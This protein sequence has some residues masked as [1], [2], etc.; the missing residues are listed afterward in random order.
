MVVG[1]IGVDSLVVVFGRREMPV[2]E[3]ACASRRRLIT[4]KNASSS[5]APS[6]RCSLAGGRLV[7]L[8][9][10]RFSRNAGSRRERRRARR[11]WDGRGT[12]FGRRCR[13]RDRRR[14]HRDRLRREDGPIPVQSDLEP[15]GGAGRRRPMARGYARDRLGRSASAHVRLQGDRRA[16][17][18]LLRAEGRHE[19]RTVPMR[20]RRGG[21]RW[22]SGEP[23]GRPSCHDA[24]GLRVRRWSARVLRRERHHGHATHRAWAGLL[25]GDRHARKCGSGPN[26]G[27][28]LV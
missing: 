23:M 2:A 19:P 13:A 11:E 16:L 22:R 17:P 10:R 1:A 18:R 25:R 6:P 7:V 12:G 28:I 21:S 5:R 24:R 3:G 8:L 9:F 20:F 15:V 27:S 4:W 26:R 14:M